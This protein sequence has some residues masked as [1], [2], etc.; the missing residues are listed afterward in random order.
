M[1]DDD[2]PLFGEEWRGLATTDDFRHRRRAG[3]ETVEIELAA[4][5]LAEPSNQPREEKLFS[6]DF[7][8]AEK[9]VYH[10]AISGSVVDG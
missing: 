7:V 6:A 3:V 9:Y 1:V 5:E 8:C 10:L 2:H 4:G